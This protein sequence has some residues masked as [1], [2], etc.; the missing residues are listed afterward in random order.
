MSKPRKRMQRVTAS[1]PMTPWPPVYGGWSAPAPA[2][3]P[4]R[5][6]GIGQ[7]SAE[8]HRLRCAAIEL[9]R[10]MDRRGFGGVAADILAHYGLRLPA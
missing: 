6:A 9:E 8:A 3:A 10:E 5:S 4:E 2:P 7:L 1:R